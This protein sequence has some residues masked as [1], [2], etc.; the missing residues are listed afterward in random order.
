MVGTMNI[1]FKIIFATLFLFLAV[2]CYRVV[3]SSNS[4]VITNCSIVN[5]RKKTHGVSGVIFSGNKIRV[6]DEST[7]REKNAPNYVA[8][9]VKNR[10]W[11]VCTTIHKLSEAIL[12]FGAYQDWKVVVVGDSNMEASVTYFENIIFLDVEKQKVFG[13]HF[14]Q[15]FDL[16]PWRHFGRKNVGYL[17]A[18]ANGAEMI[19]DFDDD[20]ILK[21]GPDQLL[22]LT[23]YSVSTVHS[24]N[25][26][27]INPL[28]F[29]GSSTDP[30]SWPRGFPLPSVNSVCELSFREGDFTNIGIFQS[31]ADHQPDVDGIYRLTRKT[32]FYF[33]SG[34]QRIIQVPVGYFT[35]FNAQATLFTKSSFWG[36]LLPVT[37]HG[38][39][40]DIWRSYIIQKLFVEY[41]QTIAFTPPLVTQDRNIHNYL[42]DME[43]ENDLY[44][45]TPA[46]IDLLENIQLKGNFKNRLRQFYVEL[47]ER[48][49]I[50]IEDV[51]LASSW[52]DCLERINYQFPSLNVPSDDS[53]ALTFLSRGEC[54]QVRVVLIT[55]INGM[56]GS[57]I[58]K[59]LSKIKCFKIH[60]L[61]RPRSNLESLSGFL[62]AV[63]LHYGDIM[64]SFFM[65]NL[66]ASV[67]PSYIF[68][69]AAQAI[70]GISYSLPRLT[71]DSN[72]IGTLN[73]LEAVREQ[74]LK[75]RI[76]LAGSSTV[77]GSAAD[78]IDGPIPETA[79]LRPV[80]PY[81][82]SKLAMENLGYQY[83][84]AHGLSVVTARFFIQIGVGGTDSLA[85]QQFCRQIA[86]AEIGV[87]PPVIFHGNLESLRDISDVRLSAGLVVK[88]AQTG[89]S[90]ESYNIGSGKAVSTRQI[91]NIA[92]SLS[93]MNFSI[94]MQDRRIRAYDEKVLLADTS[95]LTELLK[96]SVSHNLVST[97]QDIL[98]FWRFKIR[99]L[100]KNR[101]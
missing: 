42:T 100:Y 75:C 72:I 34:F 59:E 26:S 17:F 55:G 10:L 71:V 50:G 29:M 4:N 7:V 52:I 63:T 66:V 46:L 48:D 22:N 23:S 12:Q 5:Q 33:D 99:Q 74:R 73:I 1:N 86:L 54:K 38:R 69:F 20:N 16:I 89:S 43:A 81:G 64:D 82:V 28:P 14:K 30:P 84:K 41:K 8:S 80:S 13:S 77:Y 47:Y 78:E 36:L 91:L 24:S 101:I 83:F 76:I 39:V 31:L 27:S 9:R 68:H 98:N 88:L 56:I 96:V 97:I 85:V 95:K 92:L 79:P 70:N 18:I 65:T 87:V 44:M 53:K 40:S 2:C 90:G 45:K 62:D 35:P 57:H 61:V 37:V 58:S 93:K 21:T 19:W 11:A 51:R 3:F 94:S 67:R 32:P 49:F 60:G 6:F 25:C 15:F